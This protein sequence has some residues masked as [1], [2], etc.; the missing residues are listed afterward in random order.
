MLRHLF[1]SMEWHDWWQAQERRR[2]GGIALVCGTGAEIRGDKGG[3]EAAPAAA[4]GR[5]VGSTCFARQRASCQHRIGFFPTQVVWW[6]GGLARVF[7]HAV[8]HSPLA[9]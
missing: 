6:Q 2:G 9:T 8:F 5:R 4:L 3:A 1:C 7:T